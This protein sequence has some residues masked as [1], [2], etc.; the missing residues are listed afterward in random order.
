MKV[1]NLICIEV[2]A[3]FLC[4]YFS[5]IFIQ[6]VQSQ[7]RVVTAGEINLADPAILLHEGTYYLYG[8]V[9]GNVDIGFKVY[10][11]T[12]LVNWRIPEGVEGGFALHKK[13]VY[14]DRGFWAPQV[15][16]YNNRFYMA[17]TA[18]ENIAIAES[19]SPLGPFKQRQKRALEASV[20]QID[21][22]VFIADDG[23]KYLFHVRLS[24]GNRIFVAELTNDFTKI[25]EETLKECI[26]ADEDWEN[27]ANAPW[28]VAEGPSIL[29]K[30]GF[31][32]LI[33]SANDFRNS[34]Y[35]VGYAVSE[36][37]DGPWK[38]SKANPILNNRDLGVNGTGHGDF[39]TD[40]SGNLVY[41]FHTH[42]SDTTVAPRKTAIINAAFERNQLKMNPGSFFYPGIVAE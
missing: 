14:G 31:Y 26:R 19:E 30:G 33:Y 11:S 17:Y 8:T 18:N 5:L 1:M 4:F 15:F 34:D 22:F 27:T 2:R 16:F 21:P 6:E 37:L 42:Q 9:D 40:K 13:N 32:Y 3:I 10:T 36:T 20:K 23:K 41:V 39:F 35:A 7:A 28:P 12:D 29:E 25:K 38:K 24:E